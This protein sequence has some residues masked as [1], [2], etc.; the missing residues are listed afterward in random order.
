MKQPYDEYSAA[1]LSKDTETHLLMST[2][3]F[4]TKLKRK[5][6]LQHA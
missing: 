1:F 3:F 2:A 4:L 6:T 5:V